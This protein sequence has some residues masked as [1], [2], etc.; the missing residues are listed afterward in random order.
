MEA[1]GFLWGSNGGILNNAIILAV[2]YDLTKKAAYRDAV[3]RAMDYLLGY[4]GLRKS[5]VTG[6]GTYPVSHPHHRVWAN[7]PDSGYVAPPP[8]VVAGGP[9]KNIQDP[10]MKSAHL[11]E[12]ADLQAL[13]RPHRLLCHERGLHQLERTARVGLQ[14]AQYAILRQLSRR[15]FTLE[16]R[17]LL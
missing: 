1:A 5:F 4:N 14:L 11:S 2:A 12:R 17:T 13:Y 6:Y 10:E 9:N 7:D 16:E 15:E 8:G 3:T